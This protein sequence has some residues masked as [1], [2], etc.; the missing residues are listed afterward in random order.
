[1]ELSYND[2]V[3]VPLP[4]FRGF[5]KNFVTSVDWLYHVIVYW[6]PIDPPPAL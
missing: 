6:V 2:G 1:M 4:H 5:K 3:A